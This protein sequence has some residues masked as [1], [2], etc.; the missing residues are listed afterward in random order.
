M[1]NCLGYKRAKKSNAIP[2]AVP[3]YGT[4]IMP[5]AS[6]IIPCDPVIRV[7]NGN[8]YVGSSIKCFYQLNKDIEGQWYFGTITAINNIKSCEITYKDAGFVV[9][10]GSKG[11]Y[12][13]EQGK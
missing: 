8:A 11:V 6:I 1:F 13:V 3:V 12:L 7:E 4:N 5:V 2:T 10:G 9:N